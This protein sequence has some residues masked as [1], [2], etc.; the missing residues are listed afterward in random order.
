[1]G[2]VQLGTV[3]RFERR[4]KD[5]LEAYE[6]ACE[7]FTRL[8]EPG[9]VATVW[10]QTGLV[11]ENAGQFEAAEDAYRKSL[12]IEVR[13]GNVAGQAA[14][15]GQLGNL[16]A[17]KLDR[18]EQ[19]VAFY[20]QAMDKYIEIGDTAS[21]GRQRG[22]LG[23]TLRKLHDFDEA[24]HEIRRA[25]ECKEQFRHATEPWKT[26]AILA[27][28]ETD[29]GN[30]AAAAE[31]KR[32]AI[33]R[34]LAYRR[35]GGENHSPDGRLCLAVTQALLSGDSAGAASLLGQLV[36][37][38]QLP[39]QL[40]PFLHALQAIVAG[41]RDR[42]LADGPDLNYTMAAEILLLIETLEKPR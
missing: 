17:G 24:R 26:W 38:P 8:E 15:L 4:Y 13:L 32:T 11:Y 16:Y 6:E 41:S 18:A 33:A 14:T 25:I 37:N 27:G 40:R 3:R 31:A 9:S 39:A 7:L 12:V 35:D 5:A 36:A 23:E 30:Q 34:Y 29:A 2:K 22:N 42:N 28:I 21:E 1:V 20:R 10:H 19:A